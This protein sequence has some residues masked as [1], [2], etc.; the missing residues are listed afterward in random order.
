MKGPCGRDVGA[1]PSRAG[2][3]RVVPSAREG[4]EHALTPHFQGP[5]TSSRSAG[6]GRRRCAVALATLRLSDKSETRTSERSWILAN[7]TATENKCPVDSLERFAGS[8]WEV[9]GFAL[10][11]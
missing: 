3:R 4:G 6:A 11:K 2:Q 10:F 1:L 9:V 8:A 5:A 7:V